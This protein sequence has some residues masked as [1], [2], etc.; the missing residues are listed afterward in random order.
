MRSPSARCLANTV[1]ITNRTWSNVRGVR[2]VSS[3]M[4]RSLPASVQP[5]AAE[6][7]PD[8][9]RAT[10][11]ITHIVIFA[12][13]PGVKVQDTITW[14]GRTLLVRGP[15]SDQAGR[16]AAWVAYCEEQQ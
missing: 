8:H 13:D 3:S 7:V 6:E 9:L 5:A 11:V 2:T 10:A 14:Q 12:S 15:A 1:T 4:T 16:A